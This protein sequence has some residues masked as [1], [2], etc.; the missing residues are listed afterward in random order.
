MPEH[1]YFQRVIQQHNK[2]MGNK[3][4]KDPNAPKRPLSAY[5]LFSADER[6]KVSNQ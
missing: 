2:P 3:A 4:I 5:F 6:L 1:F